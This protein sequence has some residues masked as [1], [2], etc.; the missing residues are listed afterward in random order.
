MDALQRA[1]FRAVPALALALRNADPAVR[2]KAS[3]ALGQM[4]PM[5]VEAV[6]ALADVAAHDP[7]RDHPGLGPHRR[8]RAGG[9][10]ETRPSVPALLIVAL[11]G[12]FRQ[13]T[14]D[15]RR[16]PSDP[17]AAISGSIANS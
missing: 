10:V 7:D 6:P 15:C 11:W 14:D 2:A 13:F 3:G 12:L 5:A 8:P 4:G 17:A 1:G 16:G 9:G